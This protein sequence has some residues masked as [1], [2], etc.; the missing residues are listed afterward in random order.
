VKKMSCDCNNQ[1][2]Y[3][4]IFSNSTFNTQYPDVYSPYYYSQNVYN[5]YPYSAYQYQG[6]YPQISNVC[7]EL[8]KLPVV[9][10]LTLCAETVE[11]KLAGKTELKI[12]GMTIATGYIEPLSGLLSLEG[13]ALGATASVTGRVDPFTKCL[14]L[15]G[16]ACAPFGIGCLN[17]GPKSF[18]I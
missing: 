12:S 14:T 6:S 17:F 3:G 10:P 7:K 4:D 11:G 9:G 16:K 8:V 15:S 13:G 5:Q 1:E 18:C 2:Y